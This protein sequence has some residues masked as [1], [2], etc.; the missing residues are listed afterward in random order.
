M[1][2]RNND[3]VAQEIEEKGY[4]LRGVRFNEVAAK[5]RQRMKDSGLLVKDLA[6]RLGKSEAAVSRSLSG[7][8][9]LSIEQMYSLADAI[10]AEFVMVL[11]QP[12]DYKDIKFVSNCSE[13]S[14]VMAGEFP[15]GDGYNEYAA[16]TL[17]YSAERELFE[18]RDSRLDLLAA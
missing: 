16:L 4:Y 5:F 14:P 7:R 17:V 1:K 9:N 3:V 11:S 18:N 8:Q 13:N 15:R 10:E 12:D 6:E 2:K